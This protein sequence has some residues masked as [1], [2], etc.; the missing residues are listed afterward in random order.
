MYE[1]F[2]N[3]AIILSYQCHATCVI[4]YN[5]KKH[6]KGSELEYFKLN[7][8]RKGLSIPYSS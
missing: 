6:I 8:S 5:F 1:I 2:K 3:F 4:P 7:L